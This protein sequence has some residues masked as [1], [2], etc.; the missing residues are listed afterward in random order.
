MPLFLPDWETRRDRGSQLVG[1]KP[2]LPKGGRGAVPQEPQ[3]INALVLK[4]PEPQAPEPRELPP[5]P[6]A[7]TM[8]GGS[9]G[10]S[11]N[12]RLLFAFPVKARKRRRGKSS[13][14]RAITTA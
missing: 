11:Q 6:P 8:H 10:Q 13:D 12:E 7:S 3:R 5:P 9:E 4:L 14:E 1:A 2:P